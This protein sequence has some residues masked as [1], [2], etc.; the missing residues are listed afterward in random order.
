MK[1]SHQRSE[2]LEDHG[3]V[4]AR[5]RLGLRSP[6]MIVLSGPYIDTRHDSILSQVMVIRIIQLG[7]EIYFAAKSSMS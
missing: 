7:F 4:Q 5:M 6:L 1:V 2:C 3:H